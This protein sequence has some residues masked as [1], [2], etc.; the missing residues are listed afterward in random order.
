MRVLPL[1]NSCSTPDFPTTS[2]WQKDLWSAFAL[3]RDSTTW[4]YPSNLLERRNWA[5]LKRRMHAWADAGVD[6]A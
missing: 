3:S 4:L 5:R 1:T 2:Q 6:P